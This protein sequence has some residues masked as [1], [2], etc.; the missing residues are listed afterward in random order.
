MQT[1]TME[2]RTARFAGA[3][4]CWS[5]G[6]LALWAGARAVCPESAC[7]TLPFDASALSTLHGLRRP[8][9]DTVMAAST[10]LG[11][12]AV[13]APCAIGLAWSRWRRG[14]HDDARLVLA[15]LGGACLLA[16]AT[17][18]L[19]ARPR[20]DLFAPLVTMPADLSFPSA[21]TMQVAA[22]ALACVLV[23]AR[24]HAP[25]V[26]V[27]AALAVAVVALSRVYL[28]VH[29]PSDVIVAA[30][31]AIA[32]VMGLRLLLESRA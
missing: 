24:R 32:W 19:V 3:A 30:V 13:L 26:A 12:I 22:F 20:P 11:S 27:A 21:H 18:V 8:W 16:Y 23:A 15:G 6:A 9:L 31:A 29:F 4:A 17:K 2:G 5:A 25:A 10:W 14:R 7:R 1:A 28:Q